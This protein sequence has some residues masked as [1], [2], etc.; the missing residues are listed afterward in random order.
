MTLH[1]GWRDISVAFDAT[2]P[3]WPGDT[4]VECGW[5]WEMQAGASV[6]VTRW[7]MSPHVGTHADAPVHVRRGAPGADRLPLAPFVGTAFVVDVH[8]VKDAITLDVLTALGVPTGIERLLLRTGQ[9]VA[10]GAF[11]ASWPTLDVET[12]RT[13]VARG[14]R[15]LGVDAPSVDLRESKSL[16]VHHALFDGGAFVLENLDLRE[17]ASGTYE[18]MALPIRTGAVDAAPARAFL[19]P[20]RK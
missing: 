1:G 9:G 3:P 7:T 10:G 13:L 8:E 5:S 14:L 18:L 15:L 20:L 17:I 11:P 4:P 6:N 2:T 16:V 12:A 19:R